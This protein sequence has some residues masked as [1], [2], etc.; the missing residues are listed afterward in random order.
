[1]PT[2]AKNA[3]E[4]PQPSPLPSQTHLEHREGY[5]SVYTSQEHPIFNH[6]IETP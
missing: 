6:F 1:M 3:Q 5:G 4:V 2:T